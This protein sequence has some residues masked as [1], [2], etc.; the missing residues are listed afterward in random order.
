MAR[1]LLWIHRQNLTVYTALVSLVSCVVAESRT[2][3]IVKD[4]SV[5]G[6][7]MTPN[8]T[9]VSR[10]GGHSVL[11]DGRIIWLYDD[12]Q[13]MSPSGKLLSFVSNSAAYASGMH[14]SCTTVEDFGVER[15]SYDKQGK[16][17]TA[18]LGDQAVG[19]GGW[20]PFAKEEIEFNAEKKGSERIAI[21][22][23][24]VDLAKPL[25]TLSLAFAGP[26]T[27]PTPLNTS[28]A[29]LYAPL[30]YVD[31]KPEDPAQ[32]YVARGMTLVSI[33]APAAG[34]S[35]SR[36]SEL[37][38]PD[39]QI[40]F[41][42]FASVLGSAS[43]DSADSR[44]EDDR[45]MYVLGVA[46]AGLQ[47]ARVPLSKIGRSKEYAYYVPKTSTFS[48]VP[49]DPNL[50][51]SDEVYMAGT[52]TSG[53]IFFSPYFSTYI[54]TYF[55]KMVDST[56]YI[57]FLDLM[58]PFEEDAGRWVR[59]GKDGRGIGAEDAEALVRY[60]WSEEQV[61][62]RSAPGKGGFNY[63]GA[64]H[65]EYFNRRYYPDSPQFHGSGQK[66]AKEWYGASEVEESKAGGDGRHLM[67]SWTSQ[68]KGGLQ[69]GIYEIMLARV[70]FDD[71]PPMP[72]S[73]DSPQATATPPGGHATGPTS[74]IDGAPS[75]SKHGVGHPT[76]LM[77]LS[78]F[79]GIGKAQEIEAWVV[80]GE[81]ATLIGVVVAVAAVF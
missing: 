51:E 12:T 8:V 76:R 71:I 69:T 7:Q 38:F 1:S 60:A 3:I 6:P 49:P 57:R 41:G 33:T 30:V 67:L 75:P 34:P 68:K 53:N 16:A 9:N 23:S 74:T 24:G 72:D 63:A 50:A 2:P 20:I 29:L 64:S 27:S 42:G 80:M 4:V 14:L 25:L 17:E 32:M 21:C 5:I 37:I 44:P 28:H 11:L 47:L 18:I 10:D 55:N 58:K 59:G 78:A 77:T 19:D 62:Y 48:P 31:G 81:L 15:V 36:I 22:E 26:G 35:A 39:D 46:T 56:F 65:P 54:L 45:D 13:C 40:Q 79:L 70:E 52:F 61:L 66:R 43:L 73:A